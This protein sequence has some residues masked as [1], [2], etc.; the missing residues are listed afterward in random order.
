MGRPDRTHLQ[1][2]PRTVAGEKA[3]V[4]QWNNYNYR[5][6]SYSIAWQ[7]NCVPS[8]L[9]LLSII[10]QAERRLRADDKPAGHRSIRARKR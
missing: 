10:E 2:Q 1:T 9:Q 7:E 5:V 8:M 3:N 6:A 4:R